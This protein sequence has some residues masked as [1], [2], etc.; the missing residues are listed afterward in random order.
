MSTTRWVIQLA[1]LWGVQ[2]VDVLVVTSVIPAIPAMLAATR[3]PR[4]A[5]TL[6]AAAAAMAFAGLLLLSARLG[7]R[8]GHRRLLEA[9]LVVFGLAAVTG[10]T[11]HSIGQLVAA[12]I[13]Q[14]VAAAL[15][16]PAA[17]WALLRLSPEPGRRR[18]ALAGWSAAGAIA[19]VLGYVVGGGLTQL[20]SWH[21]VFWINVPITVVLTLGV[22][23][24]LPADP[25]DPGVRLDILGAVLLTAAVMAVVGSASALEDGHLVLG[26]A[27]LAAGAALGASYATRRPRV[28][29]NAGI[30]TSFVNTATTTGIA[31]VVVLILQNEMGLRPATA[32]VVMMPFSA[33]VVIGSLTSRLPSLA[34]G[35]VR[36]TT[37]GQFGIA[38]GGLILAIRHDQ[39]AAIVT[40][41]VVAGIGLG[42]TSVGATS[43]ATGTA[44]AG[45]DGAAI[46]L[47][48]TAAQLGNALGAAALLALAPRPAF[49]LVAA[50]ALVTAIAV[51]RTATRDKYSHSGGP[52]AAIGP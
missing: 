29:L 5:A 43:L 38:G 28:R 12:R 40:A 19:G 2:L 30:V 1:V 9:G 35:S 45:P 24:A 32:S 17:M 46:G 31:I 6:L 39:V 48:N 47:L 4:G 34:A 44:S 42:L 8:F 37:L 10:G 49:L 18:T 27:G 20:L 23:T 36:P 7:D 25:G 50:T 11:A 15:C 21:W 52:P 14:G 51:Y 3:A 16:V 41:T 13:G 26:V 33:A 22:M